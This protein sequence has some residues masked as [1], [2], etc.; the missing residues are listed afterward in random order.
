MIDSRYPS[1]SLSPDQVVSFD[2]I[3]DSGVLSTHCSLRQPFPH[4]IIDNFFNTEVAQ[5]LAREIRSIDD[6][7]YPVSFRSLTQRKFQLGNIRGLAPQIYP[8]YEALMKP[9]LH[10]FHRDRVRLSEPRG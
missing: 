1:A 9:S 6:N 10:T 5:S 4:V 8:L 7:N 3:G 2:L